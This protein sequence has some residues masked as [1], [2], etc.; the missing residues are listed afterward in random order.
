MSLA[1]FM[2]VG[3]SST[4][5]CAV[6]VPFARSSWLNTVQLEKPH[7]ARAWN[8]I[9][10]YDAQSRTLTREWTPLET[11]TGG[12]RIPHRS[13]LSKMGRGI[14]EDR[15]RKC[16]GVTAQEVL[17]DLLGVQDP[18]PEAS[19]LST[20]IHNFRKRQQARSDLPPRPP[21]HTWDEADWR[22]QERAWP[23][24]DKLCDEWSKC[25]W[26]AER[27]PNTLAIVSM[28]LDPEHT[29]VVYCNPALARSVLTRMANPE[30]VKLCGDGTY[31]LMREQWGL[32]T[33]GVLAKEYAKG[34]QDRMP[35]FRTTFES[36]A[37]AVTNKESE[38]NYAHLFR[39][40]KQMALVLIG[41][42]WTQRV[43]QYHCD[44]HL[45]EEA[46]RKDV[47]PCSIRCGDWAHFI[48]A[49]T[50]PKKQPLVSGDSAEA[51][52]VIVWRAGVWATVWRHARNRQALDFVKPWVCLLRTV[53]TALLFTTLSEYMF[54]MLHAMGEG[55]CATILQKHY[56]K[57]TDAADARRM[58]ALRDWEGDASFIWTADWWA[59]IERMQPGSTG[60]SQAQESWHRHKLKAFIK[61]L[62]QHIDDFAV[63]LNRMTM[64]RLSNLE[65][66]NPCL[67]DTPAEPFPDAYL[68]NG[69]SCKLVAGQAHSSSSRRRHIPAMLLLTSRCST[70]WRR[71]WQPSMSRRRNGHP[72]RTTWLSSR[73]CPWLHDWLL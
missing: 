72:H 38:D 31:R 50:R 39:A 30:Y 9:V 56:F 65:R 67:R 42:D 37:Y 36:I 28:S 35:A 45:G 18:L 14:V 2:E 32:C 68:L 52:N 57:K 19:W 26:A 17:D 5:F 49:T 69:P 27:A 43:R 61:L 62:H 59:G 54:R 46:A 64:C 22:S 51:A 8:A 16:A 58:F 13:Q 63:R 23:N 44:W 7:P 71:H 33:V 24:F 20:F 11:H 15:L 55:A 4:S 21:T 70:A 1:Q 53:P 73:L 66:A 25:G 3:A 40:V 6:H 12:E 29:C 60:G 10:A 41:S 34:E 48:G 47:F